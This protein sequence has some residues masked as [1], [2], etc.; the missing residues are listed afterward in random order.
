MCGMII[1][2]HEG[3]VREVTG[4]EGGCGFFGGKRLCMVLVGYVRIA[5]R[6]SME[7]ETLMPTHSRFFYGGNC[8]DYEFG[9]SGA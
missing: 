3:C 4:A 1:G 6:R 7:L 2:T 9:V 8:F 5:W